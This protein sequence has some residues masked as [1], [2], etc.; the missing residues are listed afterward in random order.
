MILE[1][2][3]EQGRGADT[4]I[5]CL[6]PR[7]IAATWV[8]QRVALERGERLGESVGFQVRFQACPA[9]LEGGTVEFH[10]VGV[11]LRKFEDGDR[12]ILDRY[13][14]IVIDEVHERSIDLDLLLVVLKRAIAERLAK[15][16][17]VPKIVLMSASV[18]DP[19]QF[20]EYFADSLPDSNGPR[21][22]AHKTC[23][24]LSI[25]GRT[26]PVSAIYLNDLLPII[27]DKYGEQ[28]DLLL[29]NKPHKDEFVKYLDTET[30]SKWD[31]INM[32]LKEQHAAF[33]PIDLVA[34]TIAYIA[35]S[36]SPGA[37]LVFLP[38]L[39]E[40]AAVS[41]L[42]RDKLGF[43]GLDFNDTSKFRIH[44][45]HS[46]VP[47]AVQNE[48]FEEIPIGCRRI[49]LSSNIAETSVTVPDVVHVI[50]V[51]KTRGHNYDPTTRVTTQITGW[52]TKSKAIQRE[53][54]A[55]RT[56]EGHYYGLYSY[57]RRLSMETTE[58]PTILRS[59]LTNTCLSVKALDFRGNAADFFD[60]SI[61]PPSPVAVEEAINNLKAMDALADN[62][63]I[64]SLGLLL[65]RIPLHPS[66]GKM[67]L[68][69]L[70][71]RCLGPMIVLC[72]LPTNASLLEVPLDKRYA[73]GQAH[74]KFLVSGS[75]HLAQINAFKS[76]RQMERIGHCEAVKFARTNYLNFSVYQET[77]LVM[78]Q[79]EKVLFGQGLI[80]AIPK[81]E[82]RFSNAGGIQLN[83]N[84]GNE[85]LL[86]ALLVKGL[87]PNVAVKQA[88][89]NNRTV[90]RTPT[91]GSD[92]VFL[93]SSSVN[94]PNASGDTFRKHSTFVYSQ[95]ISQSHIDYMFL[96][97][98]SHIDSPLVMA[99]FGGPLLRPEPHDTV[100]QQQPLPATNGEKF[101]F[102]Y[103]VEGSGNN[104]PQFRTPA[105][106][107]V[108]FR[109]HMDAVLNDAFRRLLYQQRGTHFAARTPR[110]GPPWAGTPEL[111]D[112]VDRLVRLLNLEYAPFR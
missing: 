78:G 47:I 52:Q 1:D 18:G 53:G 99:L 36:G 63:T 14:Y 89:N 110:T 8:A 15:G 92:F 77:K 10:T 60:A 65:R 23:P 38:G 44:S 101:A 22:P 73:A 93:H 69:G 90:V 9:K 107:L 64:T 88:S 109:E 100:V 58:M 41:Y 13:S 95:M 24:L 85:K 12:T 21:L 79:I 50:D 68:L 57:S 49:I 26:F 111:E 83:I 16:K 31:M 42:L 37:I 67:I 102:S 32:T 27:R 35:S 84:S 80:P 86:K 82:R 106:T 55:G 39:K 7:R 19:K 40:I 33:V 91:S 103:E 4:C 46:N 30:S 29:E 104:N 59:D 108:Q 75:D 56:Q 6:Q 98:V 51:G 94:S 87:Y 11:F 45:L 71:F 34:A 97:R 66:L 112:L 61:T 28:L 3:I 54:R 72:A 105:E 74:K 5:L 17:N 96:S 76:L 43:L 2:A 81:V 48:I 70:F 62:E 20:Q 25:P